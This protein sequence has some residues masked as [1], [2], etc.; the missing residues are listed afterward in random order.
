MKKSLIKIFCLSLL[1]VSIG[2]SAQH[3][4]K[5]GLDAGYTYTIMHA[6]LSSLKDSKYSGC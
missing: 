3:K 5:I 4:F 1:P 6:N 2:I